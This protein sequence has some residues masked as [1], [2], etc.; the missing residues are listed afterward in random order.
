MY[1]CVHM[2]VYV[3][4]Q[5]LSSYNNS[6]AATAAVEGKL[7]KGLKKVLKKV[8]VADMQEQ[9][10]VADSKLGQSI[11]VATP[12]WETEKAYYSTSLPLS[13]PP[14]LPPFLLT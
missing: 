4:V 7:S 13:L 14:S 2:Y 10:A 11:K 6:L 8:F 9:L 5:I 12:L 1:M 3:C